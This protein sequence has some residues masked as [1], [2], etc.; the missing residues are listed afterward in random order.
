M[1]T[2]PAVVIV[3]G[4]WHVPDHYEPFAKRLRTAGYETVIVRNP[5]VSVS[6]DPGNMLRKD[7]MVTCDVMKK[8]VN[9]E[10]KDVVIIMHSYGGVSGSDAAAML[11][12]WLG[13]YGQPDHGRVR[14]MVYLAAHVLEK[15]EPM[16]GTGRVI[17]HLDVNEKGMMVHQKP[18]ERYY[19]DISEQ[20][21]Q[22]PL[23]L[24]VPMAYS[25]FTTPTT[26]AGWRDYGIP[27][28]YIKC[29]KDNAVP[30]EM[31][32]KYIARLRE[33]GVDLKVEELDVGHSPFWID[34]DGLM[35]LI[36][37]VIE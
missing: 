13:T 4:A 12:E 36:V 34:P 37:R 22:A 18:Y 6:R 3:P 9:D 23:D 35:E 31:C 14:R 7:A 24:T 20:E 16:L 32:D 1:A 17:N 30:V 2:K 29:L 21:A 27:C 15:G 8:L 5:S 26:Y 10:T 19:A 11:C 25:A 33:G 28:T